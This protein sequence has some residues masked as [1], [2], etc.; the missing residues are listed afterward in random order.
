MRKINFLLSLFV[1][2]ASLFGTIA[3]QT[4]PSQTPAANST[5]KLSLIQGEVSS[6]NADKIVLQTKDGSMDVSLSA[7][8]TYFRVSP[9]KPSLTTA[10]A[11]NLSDI[12][13]GDKLIVTGI[14]SG[15]K[16]SV[17]A[18]KVYLM[19]KSDIAEKQSKEREQ[20]R[21]RGI[22][23]QVAAINPQTKEITVSSRSFTGERKTILTPKEDA[24]FR[25]YAQDSVDYNE[26][27][28][29]SVDEI[30][31]GDSIR[32]LGDKSEDGTT[33]KA[34]KV[35]TG[36]FKTV[37]G[38]ITA[39]SAEK[40]EITI[41]DVQT[42]KPVTIVVGKNSILKQFPAEMAQRMAQFQTGGFAPG[43]G[44]VRPPQAN[45]TSGQE[46]GQTPNRMGQGGG[47]RGGNIDDMLERFPAISVSDLKVGDMIAVSSTKNANADRVNAIKLLSGVEP[48]LKAAQQQTAARGGR[49]GQ[50]TG[51]QIPGLE[52][53]NFP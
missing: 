21:T 10:V 8:T 37:G 23:G 2:T 49:G 33:I 51:F 31:V 14:I 41:T 43:Q 9:E 15:D 38:T 4:P 50:D 34:E 45:Q 26:A 17:P 19:T 48:F 30:K 40:N 42:K 46:S 5:V 13:V 25:R 24:V 20:W 22:I 36:S 27:K 53:S 52:G 28:I 1:L 11:A 18:A 7:K 12:G 44:A 47:M 29:S 39:I 6:I 35:V 3:A 16:K 32:A